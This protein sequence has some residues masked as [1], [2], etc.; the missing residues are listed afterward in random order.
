[1]APGAEADRGRVGPIGGASDP[2]LRLLLRLEL[3][4]TVGGVLVPD[5]GELGEE[6]IV[7]RERGLACLDGFPQPPEV[8]RTVVEKR[9]VRSAENDLRT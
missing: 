3:D 4:S 2:L 7:V 1:M 6:V 5:R 9:S 8:L